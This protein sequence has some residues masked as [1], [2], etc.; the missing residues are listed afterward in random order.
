MKGIGEKKMNRLFGLLLTLAL[1]FSAVPASAQL[2][3]DWENVS[4]SVFWF[5]DAA[6]TQMVQAWPVPEDQVQHGYWV[7]LPAGALGKTIQLMITHPDYG[8]F[9]Y[10]NNG[11]SETQWLLEDNAQDL[12]DEYAM[13]IGYSYNGIP[14]VTQ[15]PDFIKLYASTLQ[16]PFETEGLP[17]AELLGP[18][19]FAPGAELIV[20]EA[21]QGGVDLIV[22]EAPQG[23]AELIVPDA[24]HGSGAELLVP[25]AKPAMASLLVEYVHEN[26]WLIDSQTKVLTPGEHWIYP[27]SPL[28][29]GYDLRGDDHTV[30]Y[31]DNSGYTQ[32]ASVTFYYCDAEPPMV[33]V[34]TPQVTE[35][36]VVEVIRPTATEEPVT[37]ITPV[38]NATITV[39]YLDDRGTPIA[40]DQTVTLPGDGTHTIHPDPAV[41]PAGYTA[42]AGVDAAQVV[43]RNGRANQASVSFY[44]QKPVQ[45]AAPVRTFDVTIYYYDT[46]NREIAPRA[47]MTVQPG[48][49]RIEAPASILNN[50][51]ELM[52][53]AVFDLTV[54]EDGS[55]DRAAE[56]VAFWYR[57]AVTLPTTTKVSV[58]Y[59][60]ES[61]QEIAA[62]HEVELA[63]GR[64]H[65][66]SPDALRVPTGYEPDSAEAIQVTVSAEGYASPA[67]V[68]FV[69]GLRREGTD[70]PAGQRI[71][72]YGI[73]NAKV[74]FRT[75]PYSTSNKTI[76]RE[77]PKGGAVYMVAN[78]YNNKGELWTQVIIDNRAGYM[79][80]KFI[81]M[82]TQEA[83]DLHARSVGATPVPT[84]TP[85]PTPTP[86]PTEVFVEY[87][88][89]VPVTP[90]PAASYAVAN[91]GTGIRTGTGSSDYIM[92]WLEQD[93]LVMVGGQYDDSQT[94]NTWC[95]IRTLDGV[96]GYV[97][98]SALRMVSQWEADWYREQWE[99]QHAAPSPTELITNTPE[100]E[101]EQGYAYVL[102]PNTYLRQM[103]SDSAS[104]MG[105]LGA[106]EIVYIRGQQFVSGAKWHSVNW[107][108]KWG[109]IRSEFLKMM[110]PEQVDLYFDQLYATPTPTATPTSRP[111]TAMMSGYGYVNGDAVRLRSEA[112]TASSSN[113]LMSLNRYAMCMV[114]DT[115]NVGGQRW[116]HVRFSRTEG[117]VH[118]A[119][120]V[121]MN[122]QEFEEFLRSDRYQQGLRNNGNPQD[123]DDVGVQG[124]GGLTSGEDE[125]LDDYYQ[126]GAQ[127]SPTHA[128]YVPPASTITNPTSTPT[129]KPG[130]GYT[131]S[132]F[133]VE[134]PVV[135][136]GAGLG[137]SSAELPLPGETVGTIV[138]PQSTGGTPSDGIGGGS[139]LAAIIV[140]ALLAVAGVGVIAVVQHQRK[141][142]RIA[143]RAAQRR[144]QQARSSAQGAYN[145]IG[146]YFPQQSAAYAPQPT[147]SQTSAQAQQN[148]LPVYGGSS[149][150]Q[151]QHPQPAVVDAQPA[152]SAPQRPY[153][154]Q[155]QPVGSP[156]QSTQPRVGRRTAY[157]QALTAQ[158]QN[159]NKQN[160]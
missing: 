118:S 96:A 29:A 17:G 25:E 4:V 35:R 5:D 79:Q 8:Y 22:P 99:Q 32:T 68:N 27:E 3:E 64:S 83:S 143:M 140:V 148:P 117:Y 145:R 111:G 158:Q 100:P 87:I 120:F 6:N 135:T 112:S 52:S 80:T 128:P 121:E 73:V 46:E 107:N 69:F 72:R 55:Y 149:A 136:G 65:R 76:I 77:V 38:Q 61:G 95:Y 47:T 131:G 44:F 103:A 157:Q 126:S 33:E 155:N 2:I 39:R 28:T 13:Y 91:W 150:A 82:L 62:A 134:T 138:P 57:P 137:E 43:V 114:L 146:T 156:Q 42:F 19:T 139:P 40:S 36:P 16:P 78:E 70:A 86:T 58:R 45:T 94:R 141:R 85:A 153:A 18:E 15:I 125:L 98:L 37:Q 88:T 23:G 130:T 10:F 116:Y 154:R 51:F 109:Y 49:H 60:N 113:T 159:Q 97:Q 119:Y 108:N 75:E 89:P 11:T 7:T 26:G 48:V 9:F 105:Q 31:V 144:A 133:P 54:Y 84:F 1:L 142:R 122:A 124:S 53:D 132:Y 115:V 92:D 30:V 20:P 104:I 90:T 81:D 12:S 74:R 152:P 129:R 160:P 24:P 56:D 14:Q 147:A 101:Q 63:V 127:Q 50:G 34:I 66:V 71:D 106:G 41:I 67:V 151:P 110:T 102:I 93:E 21:P 123:A 59:L